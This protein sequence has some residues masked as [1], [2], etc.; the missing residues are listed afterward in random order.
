MTSEALFVD[1]SL[2]SGYAASSVE[3]GESGTRGLGLFARRVIRTGETIVA[4]G[5]TVIDRATLFGLPP[6]TRRHALQIDD[7]LFLVSDRFGPADYVNHSCQPNAG[8]RGQV[9]LVAMRTISA[10]EEITYD[11]ATSDASDYDEFACACGSMRCRGRVSG[12][13]WQRPELWT[14][15]PGYFSP[16]VQKR[17]DE[18]RVQSKRIRRKAGRAR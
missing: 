9:V 5:G 7:G 12:S 15:Y 8:L 17:I 4:F 18:L 13:D 3:A 2:P 10:G 1:G 6:G 11:Y 14:Q 16:Y